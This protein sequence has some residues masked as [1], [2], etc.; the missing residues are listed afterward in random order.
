VNLCWCLWQT[1]A[2][3][4]VTYLVNYKPHHW[5][6][7][8]LVGGML[9]LSDTRLC[10]RAT[11]LACSLQVEYRHLVCDDCDLY[12]WIIISMRLL[13]VLIRYEISSFVVLLIK[14]AHKLGLYAMSISFI[15]TRPS[16]QYSCMVWSAGWY[17][18]WMPVRSMHLAS[19]VCVCC[20]ASNGTN[21]FGTMTYVG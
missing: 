18:R 8:I 19:G 13:P 21:L 4:L 9:W 15:S 5:V 11:M 6:S 14:A 17:L 2:W 1:C 10:V 3:T 20:S 16:Y 7:L 12:W